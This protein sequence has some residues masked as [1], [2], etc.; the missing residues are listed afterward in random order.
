M[1]NVNTTQPLEVLVAEPGGKVSGE[2]NAAPVL[3]GNFF[4][5][6]DK[7]RMDGR[8]EETGYEKVTTVD[9]GNQL[10]EFFKRAFIH[11]VITP[12]LG[13]IIDAKGASEIAI[14]GDVGGNKFIR[15]RRQTFL[16]L[17]AFTRFL[18]F[19]FVLAKYFD[20]MI[21]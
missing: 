11:E 3:G 10:Q 13:E 15:K 2:K 6:R 5:E 4:Q 21:V 17:F 14:T 12:H 18:I 16:P 19:L 8:F 1:M 9:K 20:C 7:K